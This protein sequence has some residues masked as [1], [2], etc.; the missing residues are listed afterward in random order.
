MHVSEPLVSVFGV[1]SIADIIGRTD[2]DFQPPL[3][4]HRFRK[5]DARIMATGQPLLH[6]IEPL[7]EHGQYVWYVTHKL[8]LH[9]ADGKIIGVMGVTLPKQKICP[10]LHQCADSLQKAAVFVREN[11]ASPLL[12]GDVARHAA[13]SARRL[14]EAFQVAFRM[15]AQQFISYCR[16]E[17]AVTDLLNTNKAIGEIALEHGFCDQSAFTRHFRAITGSSPLSFRTQFA[18]PKRT[19]L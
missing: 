3:V 6:Y 15:P 5:D 4:A 16:V 9:G 13:M 18:T 2:M 14:N 11:H 1:R 17:G 19:A 7:F 10:G 12:V 8:P